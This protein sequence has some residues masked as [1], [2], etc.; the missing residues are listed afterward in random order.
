MAHVVE[1]EFPSREERQAILREAHE[2]R[3]E[4]INKAFATVWHALRRRVGQLS[5]T[6]RAAH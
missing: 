6:H 3:G 5:A 1:T 4:T 2:L